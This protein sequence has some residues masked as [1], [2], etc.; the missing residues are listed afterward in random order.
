MIVN[1]SKF[2]AMIIKRGNKSD[3]LYYLAIYFT[4]S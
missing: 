4:M 1:L 2:Q 3:T